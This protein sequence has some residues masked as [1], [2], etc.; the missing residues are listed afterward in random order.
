MRV[1][2]QTLVLFGLLPVVLQP[3]KAAAEVYYEPGINPYREQVGQ[4]GVSSVD[5][6]TGALKVRHL[7]LLIPGNGGLD[8][9]VMRT[10]DSSR[11]IQFGVGG[12]QT[13]PIGNGWIFHFG[14]MSGYKVCQPGTAG[15]IPPTIQLPDGAEFRLAKAP[16][17]FAHLYT[18]REGWVAD[19]ANASTGEGLIVYSPEGLKYE[20]TVKGILGAVIGANIYY[21]KKITDRHGNW[22]SFD[23][24]TTNNKAYVLKLTA[25]DGRVVDFRYYPGTITGERLAS[26]SADGRSWLFEY[27]YSGTPVYP[28]DKNQA[29]ELAKVTRPDGSAWSYEYPTFPSNS[30]FVTA[31][32]Y[33]GEILTPQGGAEQY[34][35]T[36][37]PSGVSIKVDMLRVTNKVALDNVN[38][39]AT[40]TY[41]YR[42]WES[43]AG[44]S[45]GVSTTDVT[46]PAGGLTTYKFETPYSASTASAWR[47]G[48]QLDKLECSS[49]AGVVLTCDPLLAKNR[50]QMEWGS[51]EISTDV[52]WAS[53]GIETYADSRTYR[54]LL[55]RQTVTRDGTAYVTQY[56]GHDSYGNPGRLIETGN[57][58]ARTTDVTYF[59][60][61]V[62]W[63][64]G[65]RDKETIDG[66]WIVDRTFDVNGNV[67]SVS[68]Y[69]V[70][71]SFT[72]HASGDLASETDARG[73]RTQYSDYF[74]GVARRED[75]PESVTIFRTVNP[76]GTVASETNGEGRRTQYTYDGLNRLSSVL[77]PA[78]NSTAI[79]WN[80]GIG[81]VEK[82]MTRGN[83]EEVTKFDG[84]GRVV[85]V[86]KRDK[87]T[88]KFVRRAYG[89]D[90][91]ARKTMESYPTSS[92]NSIVPGIQYSYDSL[93]RLTQVKH[94]DGKLRK[95]EY[96][97]GNKIRVT[98]ENGG[99]YVYTYRSYGEP[100]ERELLSV[101]A[102]L[103]VANLTITRNALG[104]VTSLV[105][106]GMTRTFQ[107]DTRGYLA[108][109]NHPEVGWVT[110]GRDAL[111]NP[112]TKSV[113]VSPN[114]R[115]ISYAYDARNRLRSTTYPSATTPAVTL[116]YNR[117]DDVI[118]TNRG[119]ISRAY[120][121]DAN[122]NLID[123]TLYVDGRTFR[124]G[125]AYD[126]NDALSQ[127][128][129]P[130]GHTV[131]YYPDAL[132]RPTVALPY[133]TGI[134]YHPSGQVASLSYLNGTT[135]TQTFNGRLWPQ[136]LA[137]RNPS[138]ALLNTTYTYDGLG[139]VKTLVDGVD[140]TLSRTLGYDA[141]D[142]LI[143]AT[144]PWGTGAIA[145]D[146]RGN[147]V[148]Q[149]YGTNYVTTYTYDTANRLAAYNGSTAFVYD[150]WGNATRSGNALSYHLFDDASNLY[151]ASCDSSSPT[152]FEYDA[153]NYRVK[154]SRNGVVTYALY[155]KDGNLMMEYTPSTGDL[156]EFAYHNKKQVAMRHVVDSAL[157][158]GFQ[159][160]SGVRYAGNIPHKP[161][162]IEATLLAELATQTPLLSAALLAAS[163]N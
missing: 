163:N 21:V 85:D 118:G 139:N 23:Y 32:G 94:A 81:G 58:T 102:P 14:Y 92:S 162:G 150:V 149:T 10:Y 8:I 136:Q 26:I 117:V 160:T 41:R 125:Y 2:F 138:A 38:P 145:Y 120:G 57:G 80:S 151:C 132:G 86:T 101:A 88:G 71:T 44:S 131:G 79:Q 75:Q 6:Y 52:H 103:A 155:A 18:S 114:V 7:D 87:I 29:F 37:V 123:E 17:G 45:I 64:T 61:P 111:G 68:K 65:V 25:N 144:G 108:K 49:E 146:G 97:T 140:A 31:R 48:L 22:L 66:T 67:L 74:R 153:S 128:V 34:T 141:I 55:T 130:D 110:Y 33:L 157:V 127:V 5:P 115:T 50:V 152:W 134:T 19:C 72:Y 15:H 154:K 40:W 1:Y 89:Y 129:Y 112:L 100:E 73:N 107:Y 158:L 59:N 83:L 9:K 54:P 148:S 53:T 12:G 109:V 16:V 24:Q 11:V 126:G 95:L 93:G 56:Q 147:V 27:A 28:T 70:P 116:T 135:T 113:G 78:G 77:P 91:L 51:Q 84:F 142:R 30:P 76:G 43:V 133:V 98:N 106:A 104:Q 121:Y 119:A 82:R 60:D 69:G 3:I 156:K 46:D 99:A 159:D 137:V 122:R 62:K 20:M 39:A 161:P 143:S 47:I 124:L 42:F 36:Y 105:Q 96:L 90:A 4:D 13:S 63:I 35:Y